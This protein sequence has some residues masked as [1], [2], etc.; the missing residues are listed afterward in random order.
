MTNPLDIMAAALAHGYKNIYDK[1]LEIL[2][3]DAQVDVIFCVLGE[4]T[5]KTAL[6]VAKRY[7]TKPLV[8]WVIGQSSDASWRDTSAVCY[9]SPER[10][11]RALTAL[12]EHRAFLMETPVQRK[13]FSVDR[14]SAENILRKARQQKQ[15]I[16][17]TE[18]F[19]IV[20]TYGIPV[21][22][23][24][25]AK[26]KEQ[27]L[28]AAKLLEYPVV[29]KIC[30]SEILHK[31]DVKGVRVG[32]RDP[33]ELRLHYED[34]ISEVYREAPNIKVEGVL[35]QQMVEHGREIILGAKR[36]PD[37]GPVIIFG[38]GGVFTEVLR[39]FSCGI[40]PLTDEEA[41]RMISSTKVSRV[42]NEFRGNPPADLFFL[43][44]C[45]LRISQ[46]V[47][48]FPE[49]AELDINPIKVFSKGGIAI[50]VRA[51]ID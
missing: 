46:L 13:I 2:F 11:F 29:L 15:R 34:I 37:F 47:S 43:K 39:D 24:K 45:I 36:D 42:L 44:E 6:E 40:V 5:L 49:I 38:W 26:S 19:S 20:N 1:A 16:L 51:V 17:T 27:A 9:Q 10:G 4:P 3:Q 32:I 35:V 21:A 48:E 18:A 25:V 31:S 33:K 14:K 8:S 30:S 50:D 23:F 12:L 41:E 7:P 28:N 22:R